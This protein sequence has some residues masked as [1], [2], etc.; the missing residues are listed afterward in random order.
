MDKSFIRGYQSAIR[1]PPVVFGLPLKPL[2]LGHVFLLESLDSPIVRGGSQLSF[3]DMGAA[4]FACAHPHDK[5]IKYFSAWWFPLFTRIWSLFAKPSWMSADLKAFN[6]YLT[7]GFSSPLI[8]PIQRDGGRVCQSPAPW[9]KLLFAMHVLGMTRAEAMA[10]EIVE[11]NV[12]YATWAEWS[13]SGEIADGSVADDLWA[14]AEEQARKRMEER[15]G[16]V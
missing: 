11:M 4:V 5:A 1:K 16:A 15:S 7:D 6:E 3:A 12:L 14:F 8:R 2:T 10:T 13:G 9:I